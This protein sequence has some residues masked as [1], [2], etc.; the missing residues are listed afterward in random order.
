[1]HAH[2]D[3]GP[4]KGNVVIGMVHCHVGA[5]DTGYDFL[6]DWYGALPFPFSHEP[7]VHLQNDPYMHSLCIVFF[8]SFFYN[9]IWF[10]DP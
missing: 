5:H 3:D 4:W 9:V 1:M 8:F 2:L 10:F 7:N 6:K